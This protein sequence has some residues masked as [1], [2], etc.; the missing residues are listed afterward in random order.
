MAFLHV[1]FPVSHDGT[2][3]KTSSRVFAWGS[4]GFRGG[5]VSNGRARGVGITGEVGRSRAGEMAGP[6]DLE[7]SFFVACLPPS[8]PPRES[9]VVVGHP[10]F[11]SAD[12][13]GV[14]MRKSEEE[15][16]MEEERQE[17]E[18]APSEDAY[19]EDEEENERGEGSVRTFGEGSGDPL[20]DILTDS[21]RSRWACIPFPFTT[22]ASSLPAQ[23]G[24]V[25]LDFPVSPIR[26]L[27]L[28][29]Q[30]CFVVSMV[31][32]RGACLLPWT[33]LVSWTSLVVGALLHEDSEDNDRILS[34]SFRRASDRPMAS[35][36]S[37]F[38]DCLPFAVSMAWVRWEDECEKVVESGV[39]SILRFER[40]VAGVSPSRGMEE[41][42][43][44]GD[45]CGAL[46]GWPT[47]HGALDTVG[48]PQ[49]A[50]EG[51]SPTHKE[52]ALPISCRTGK[53]PSGREGREDGRKR[54]VR[55]WGA[56][57]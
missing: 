25:L 1:S 57:Q 35:L 39:L 29:S 50:P 22:L 53:N 41:V 19:D 37:L 30:L 45:T 42:Q 9:M 24:G 23:S 44:K 7:G 51:T 14:G 11:P 5:G 21:C 13:S 16:I 49:E 56:E 32:S 28:A 20:G 38:D 33:P 48:V 47:T 6:T 18:N 34:S 15:E 40:A 46:A 17:E 2:A 12:N 3:G 36:V 26:V 55:A 31:R 4:G 43:H 54:E 52:N 8:A 27:P 10:L